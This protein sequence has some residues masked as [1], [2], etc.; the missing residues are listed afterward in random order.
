MKILL[1]LF[2]LSSFFISCKDE[3]KKKPNDIWSE[4]KF[5]EALVEIQV[6]EAYVRLGFNRSHESYRPKDS[7]FESTFRKLG[8]SRE[9]FEKNF[10]YYV[11]HPKSMDKIYEEVIER[12]SERQAE[13]QGETQQK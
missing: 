5:I 8:V 11:N 2:V 1:I 3:I 4:E 12:L 6:T 7:L 13:L 9:E 10:E